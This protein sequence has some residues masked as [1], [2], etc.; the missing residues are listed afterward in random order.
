MSNEPETLLVDQD[1]LTLDEVDLVEDVCQA[2]L[3]EVMEGKVRTGRVLRAFAL[4][5]ARRT[6]PSATLESLGK[7]T[8][9]ELNKVLAPARPFEQNE[10][11]AT[12][13]SDSSPK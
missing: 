4:V 3:S 12:S 10:P 8:I 11:P 9:A 13:P 5:G 7:I 2:S 6:D 1:N